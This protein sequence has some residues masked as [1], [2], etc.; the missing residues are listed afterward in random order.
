MEDA[1]RNMAK[2]VTFRTVSQPPEQPQDFAEF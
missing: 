2:A 1:I